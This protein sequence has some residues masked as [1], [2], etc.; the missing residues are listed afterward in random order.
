M[1]K[2]N[3]ETCIGCGT[4]AIICDKV[5]KINDDEMKAEVIDAEADNECV[6]EAIDACPVNAISRE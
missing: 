4:C 1:I 5:F 2:I 6:Q 3:K